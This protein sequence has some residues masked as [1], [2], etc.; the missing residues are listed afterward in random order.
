MVSSLG[1]MRPILRPLVGTDSAAGKRHGPAARP[2][3]L[4][5][6]PIARGPAHS[7]LASDGET[8]E[9]LAILLEKTALTV[10]KSMSSGR[11]WVKRS[12][13]TASITLR[14][15]ECSDDD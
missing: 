14:E 5:S 13:K 10:P 4:R 15:H 1:F 8:V 7:R 2:I 11:N 3:G 6:P 9:R 12:R